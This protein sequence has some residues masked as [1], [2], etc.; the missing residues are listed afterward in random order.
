VVLGIS[1]VL[2]GFS[3]EGGASIVTVG[4]LGSGTKN[5]GRCSYLTWLG[6]VWGCS[7]QFLP[8]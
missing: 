4:W 5:P 7:G 8:Y 3:K 6:F 1:T 2:R